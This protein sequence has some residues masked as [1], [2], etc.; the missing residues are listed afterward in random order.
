MPPTLFVPGSL[1]SPVNDPEEQER[2]NKIVPIDHC[3]K[4]FEQRLRL[5]GVYNRVLI[6]KAGTASSK[7]TGFVA[8][9]YMR[10]VQKYTYG[11]RGLICTQPKRITAIK[12]VDQ[13][14]SVPIYA[15]KL[16]K[17]VDIGWS[18]Q[19]DK[20]KPE[21]FGIL[22]A[23]VGTLTAQMASNNDADILKMYQMIMIDETHERNIQTDTVI[24]MLYE[25]LERNKDKPECPFVVFMSATFDPNE[26][27]RYFKTIDGQFSLANNF[28]H[29]VGQSVGYDIFWPEESSINYSEKLS[30]M[31]AKNVA[32]ILETGNDDTEDS[33][34]ILI[35]MPGNK[36]IQE[37]EQ[38]LMPII[39]N[40]YSRGL[41]LSLILP[42]S[43]K[44]MEENSINY[45]YLDKKN[46][47]IITTAPDGKQMAPRRKIVISTAIAETGLTLDQLKYIIENGF[48]RGSLFNPNYSTRS[49]ITEV[50]P[51][52]RIT[53]RFGRVGRKTRGSVY[54]LYS[55]ETYS[56]FP[57]QQFPEI[58][59]NDYS[60]AILMI[61]MEKIR[62]SSGNID[63]SKDIYPEKIN[64]LTNPTTATKNYTYEMSYK[65]GMITPGTNHDSIRLT[66]IG[67]V[68]ARLGIKMTSARL[69]AA[70]V[71]N[72][73][74]VYDLVSLVS[75]LEVTTG[76]DFEKVNFI[77][78]YR[79]FY[80]ESAE[81]VRA[82]ISDD[83]IDIMT[84]MT[85]IVRQFDSGIPNL[86]S[87]FKELKT[88]EKIVVDILTHRD[89]LL[90]NML[91]IG[92]SVIGPERYSLYENTKAD[93]FAN[94]LVRVKYCLHDAFK[95][96]VLRLNSDG[97][98]YFHGIQVRV[99]HFKRNELLALTGLEQIIYPK[100]LVFDYLD[101]TI[102]MGKIKVTAPR[103]STM[104]GYCYID[105]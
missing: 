102:D 32:K 26:F 58:L 16:K 51:K 21:R 54:P 57:E 11:R 43:S 14:I 66:K 19:F 39:A 46:S 80:G 3:E 74:S 92:Y 70:G 22:S 62:D 72:G 89:Q 28:I 5:T 88:N 91:T 44:E 4:W 18:T 36:E 17:G 73:Y 67:A 65:L 52:S 48:H 95:C 93:T 60:D 99:P 9:M 30:K 33:C 63:L 42:I 77:P 104:S 97:N 27:V 38:E 59:I 79:Y 20:L 23:T 29:V 94:I 103:I 76:R 98:Y 41:G 10:I 56:H 82:A 15:K 87:I 68:S 31:A 2:L 86:E 64:M 83:F 50:A 45:R 47:D 105:Q 13:I 35:F 24:L 100:L 34:D 12:N 71:I 53:Q 84:F 81:K 96:G 85:F 49:I 55:L 90:T 7:S 25:F 6:L 8:E 75:A 69:L 101:S 61:L 40:A 37:T 78:A 1:R